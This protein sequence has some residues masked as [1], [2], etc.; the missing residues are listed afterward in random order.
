MDKGV[1]E[2]KQDFRQFHTLRKSE[3]MNSKT[4]TISCK[5]KSVS[6]TISALTENAHGIPYGFVDCK[7]S[8]EIVP[9]HTNST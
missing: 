7:S 5:Q 3:F 6:T 4:W 2:E 8:G 9:D 1:F